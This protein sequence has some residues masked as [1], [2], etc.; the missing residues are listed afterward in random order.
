LLLGIHP[1]AC[2]HELAS[3]P[4]KLEFQLTGNQLTLLRRELERQPEA[5]TLD[6]L[7]ARAIEEDRLAP[8]QRRPGAR[9]GP[10][11]APP[12]N[13]HLRLERIVDAGTA[14]T[15]FL[16]AGDLLSLEQIAEGQC[17]DVNV[18]ALEDPSQHFSAART[19]AMYGLHPSVGAVLWST[20]PERPLMTIVSDTAS[21]HDLSFPAC[22][23]FEYEDLAGLAG[24]PNCHDLL[25]AAIAASECGP[26]PA[27]D[28]LNLWLPS[29]VDPG[30]ILRSWPVAARR[31]DFVELQASTYVLAVICP[32][33]DDL[34][35]SSQY[36][37]SA[38]RLR[39]RNPRSTD[40]DAVS[41]YVVTSPAPPTA[42]ER[43]SV[44]GIDIPDR[45]VA[46]FEELR[47]LGWLGFD[48][49]AVARALVLQSSMN[50]LAARQQISRASTVPLGDRGRA[51]HPHP[52]AGEP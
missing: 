20:P 16:Q 32:C 1:A 28:P 14:A 4:L 13:D 15:V 44:V 36:D 21:D 51:S 43:R 10:P 12:P 34:F 3:V 46:H 29:E 24:H 40:G 41:R 38:I 9:P 23:A 48:N 45:L 7:V 17:V 30:G 11:L 19:R 33:P 5:R 42:G 25:A 35:G 26:A 27:H 2:P 8:E 22:S 37:P 6:D 39:V 47:H 49:A 18:F 50:V 31:G 52:S